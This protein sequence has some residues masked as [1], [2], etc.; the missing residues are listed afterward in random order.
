MHMH[1]IQGNQVRSEYKTSTAD[2]AC[3]PGIK[4][5]LG[6]ERALKAGVYLLIRKHA[7]S[8]GGQ[9]RHQ[10]VFKYGAQSQICREKIGA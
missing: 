1:R 9:K 5:G 2:P 10:I 3:R 7:G 6:I 4:R 8:A